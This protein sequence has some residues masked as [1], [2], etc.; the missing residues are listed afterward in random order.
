M[1]YKV[2]ASCFWNKRVYDMND[3]VDIDPELNPPKHFILLSEYKAPEKSTLKDI[4]APK[5]MSY[6]VPIKEASGFA[7]KLETPNPQPMETAPV[8]RKRG[9]K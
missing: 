1:K 7:A 2:L 5:P 9:R 8:L 3:V 6:G 4:M